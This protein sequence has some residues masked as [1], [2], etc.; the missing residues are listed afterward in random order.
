M[1]KKEQNI[2]DKR[3]KTNF[4]S[5]K[6]RTKKDHPPTYELGINFAA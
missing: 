3:E 6:I 2:A 1:G 4:K 5:R